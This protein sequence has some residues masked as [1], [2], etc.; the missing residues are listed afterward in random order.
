MRCKNC[1]E[2]YN[3]EMFPVCP[4]CLTENISEEQYEDV[5]ESFSSN[6]C[7]SEK[8]TRVQEETVNEERELNSIIELRHACLESDMNDNIEIEN[9][10]ELSNRSKNTL[11]RNG[12]FSLGQLKKIIK[13]EKLLILKNL[14]KQSKDEIMAVVKIYSEK[15]ESGCNKVEIQ[16]GDEAENKKEFEN[17]M[18]GYINNQVAK[19]DISVLKMLGIATRT[20]N[21]LNNRGIVKV[22]NLQ[23]I[24]VQSLARIVGNSNIEKFK[25]IESDLKKNIT[26][27]LGDIWEQ[28]SEE[29]EFQMV[30][31]KSDGFTLQDIGELKGITRER[32]R[33]VIKK[34]NDKVEPLVMEIVSHFMYPKEYVTLQELLDIYDNDDFD[35]VLINWCKSS[36]KLEYLDFAE[37]FVLAGEDKNYY[38]NEILKIAIDFIGEGIDLYENIEEL[39]SILHKN[40]FSYID[41]GD[42][43][44]LVQKYGYKVY[45]S[46]IVKGKQ[47]YGFLC[48]RI[49]A[50]KFPNGIKLHE[51]VDLDLLRR[52]V[53]EEYGDIGVSDNDRAFSTRL[54]A[55]LVLSGRGE[56]TA[57]ENVHVELSML[58]EIK[59]Y[60]DQSSEGEIYYS[61]LFSE[62]E[63]IIQMMSNIDNYNFLHGVLMLYYPDEYTYTRD[64]LKKKGTGYESGKISDKIKKY[65]IEKKQ[66]LHKN[67]IKRKYSGISD[68]VLANAVY[69][70]EELFQWDYNY[71]FVSSLMKYTDSDLNYLTQTIEQIMV[72]NNGYCSDNLLVDKVRQENIQFLFE[73]Q[74]NT[75]NNLYYFCANKLSEKFDFRRPHIVRKGMLQNLYVK[76]IALHLLNYPEK[77]MYSKYVEISHK[78]KW[79]DVTSSMVFK[80]IEQDYIRVSK[81]CY[82]KKDVFTIT[83]SEIE[84]IENTVISMMQQ[85]I[86]SLIN[87][88]E[89]DEFS[90]IK[91]EWNVYLLHT[92][93]EKYSAKL[94]I[95]ENRN[96]DRR[97]E[98][99]IIVQKDANLK[100]YVD[101]VI[102]IL[103]AREKIEISENDMLTLMILNGL[104]YKMIPKEVYISDKIVYKNE[105]FIIA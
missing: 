49:V 5:M 13:D 80:E 36:E 86:L 9:I 105:K 32:V 73:N 38:E 81:D 23:N 97:Y 48:A 50:K 53:L 64:F 89:W 14:G 40:G 11:R 95:I 75:A 29:D 26:E 82:V 66:P 46:Y 74:M 90:D 83:E 18:F 19:L 71:Y 78:L 33:Q 93:I 56:A 59:T 98:R 3:E 85:G 45:G 30:L 15:A 41:V 31:K 55:H 12:V 8:I 2:E 22:E 68:I 28:M 91:Y 70:D 88:D 104:T 72:D 77:L 39:D 84:N 21:T 34:F 65:I 102:H 79:A 42:I 43:M 69:S 57:V 47:S 4:Y 87:F 101:V 6:D 99:G 20:I 58:E 61:H 92:I 60:I 10:P 25:S 76:D 27:L 16:R 44:S 67:E 96:K 17:T 63:G 24:S 52:Y 54:A 35:K 1:G 7:N 37:V 94:K 51:G 100:N 62:F 103:K